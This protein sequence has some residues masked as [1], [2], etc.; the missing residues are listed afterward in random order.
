M[1]YFLNVMVGY[2][3]ETLLKT[4]YTLNNGYIQSYSYTP[5]LLIYLKT[6]QSDFWFW[7]RQSNKLIAVAVSP[8]DYN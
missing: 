5:K 6:K 2:M 1:F 4:N 7:P 3:R 8:N